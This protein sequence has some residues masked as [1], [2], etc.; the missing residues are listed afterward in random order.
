[1]AGAEFP[2]RVIARGR[3]LARCG[4]QA[5]EERW[6]TA[7]VSIE[8]AFRSVR[9]GS[10][11]RLRQAFTVYP[12][13]RVGFWALIIRETASGRRWGL[14]TQDVLVRLDCNGRVGSA[15]I[16]PQRRS[17]AERWSRP[18]WSGWLWVTAVAAMIGCV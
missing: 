11:N 8:A 9:C 1:M 12:T 5:S 2:L 16:R 10:S 18:F 6:I 7:S 13:I 14:S 17:L 15:H 3:T 4:T